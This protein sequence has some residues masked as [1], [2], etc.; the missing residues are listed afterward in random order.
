MRAAGTAVV[1]G[2]G[3]GIGAATARSLAAQ[4]YNVVVVA[5]TGSEVD[6]VVRSIVDAGGRARGIAA[7]L[8]DDTDYERVMDSIRTVEPGVD[9]LVVCAGTA[10]LGSS[11]HVP[12]RDLEAMLRLHIVLPYRAV[13]SL[14]GQLS[15]RQGRVVVIGSRA[16]RS[17]QPRAVAYGTSKAAVAYL[18]RSLAGDL[19]ADGISACAINPGA[20][21]TRLR[22]EAMGPDAPRGTSP[23]AVAEIVRMLAML[24]NAELN[25][26]VVDLPW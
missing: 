22:R 1:L 13:A 10:R 5:R 3:R 26:T 24:D 11:D 16:G 7:D 12:W 8:T 23:D 2:A 4:G 6:G 21:D 15:R 17:P 18:V 25:G 9:V 14:R 20:V 19:K